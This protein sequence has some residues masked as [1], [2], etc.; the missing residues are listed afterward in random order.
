MLYLCSIFTLSGRQPNGDYSGKT[1]AKLGSITETC[2]SLGWVLFVRFSRMKKIKK[3]SSIFVSIAQHNFICFL[4]N[5][6]LWTSE[7]YKLIVK[8]I[9]LYYEVIIVICK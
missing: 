9:V 3:K 8:T 7:M 6:I 1:T 4:K 5:I 2:K